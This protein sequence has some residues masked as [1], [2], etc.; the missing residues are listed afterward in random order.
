MS[1]PS[2]IPVATTQIIG[3]FIETFSYGIYIAIFPRCM[4]IFCRRY[5]DGKEHIGRAAAVYFILTM[6]LL[7]LVITLVPASLYS[8][9]GLSDRPNVQQHV[10]TNLTRVF[11]AFTVIIT[12]GSAAEVYFNNGN[13]ALGVCKVASNVTATLIGDPG[14][15]IILLRQLPTK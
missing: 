15:G 1:P 5:K 12:I 10:V 2:T 8:S 11:Q 4:A 9:H 7:L 3:S 13:T 6:I 14:H